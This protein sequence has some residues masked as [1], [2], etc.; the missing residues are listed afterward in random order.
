M[1]TRTGNKDRAHLPA[2]ILIFNINTSY[3][4][5]LENCLEVIVM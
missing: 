1:H 3:V 5:L 2:L 4:A